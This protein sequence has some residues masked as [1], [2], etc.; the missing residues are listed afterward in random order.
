MDFVEQKVNTASF[1]CTFR[2]NIVEISQKCQLN[3]KEEDTVDFFIFT[4]DLEQIDFLK[5]QNLLN[6]NQRSI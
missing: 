4:K 1:D 3:V 2:R 6:E 5:S